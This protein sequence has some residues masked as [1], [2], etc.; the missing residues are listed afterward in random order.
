MSE[1]SRKDL[2]YETKQTDMFVKLDNFVIEGQSNGDEEAP[3]EEAIPD[4]PENAS[5]R[6]TYL[7]AS[8]IYGF[9]I[10]TKFVWFLFHNFLKNKFQSLC[11]YNS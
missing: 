6:G 5:A 1:S 4:L 8:W 9:F 2:N 7:I 11:L 3:P 10:C